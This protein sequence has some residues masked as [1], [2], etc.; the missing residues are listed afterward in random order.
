MGP[1]RPIASPEDASAS[2]HRETAVARLLLGGAGG[3]CSPALL[4]IPGGPHSLRPPTLGG[5]LS[6][7]CLIQKRPVRCFG[8]RPLPSPVT[9]SDPAPDDP[10][11]SRRLAL[12]YPF[13]LDRGHLAPYG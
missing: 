7:L 11:L 9:R 3:P 5:Q 2:R 12:L 4:Y 6:R 1:L 10:S 8:L 13:A